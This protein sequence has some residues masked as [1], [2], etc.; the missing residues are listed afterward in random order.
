MIQEPQNS[1]SPVD[2]LVTEVRGNALWDALKI[3]GWYMSA[4]LI[5]LIHWLQ[6]ASRLFVVFILFLFWVASLLL[7]YLFE[8]RRAKKRKSPLILPVG[9]HPFPRNLRA[10]MIIAAGVFAVVFALAGM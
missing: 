7:F 5:T 9:Y 1:Q 8:L 6:N 2:K 10:K 4:A 3:A